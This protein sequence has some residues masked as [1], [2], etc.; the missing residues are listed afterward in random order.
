MQPHA[1]PCTKCT[2]E[3]KGRSSSHRHV[4]GRRLRRRLNRGICHRI[5]AVCV[6]T[7]TTTDIVSL[8]C[9]EQSRI[10]SALVPFL[11]DFFP[12]AHGHVQTTADEHAFTLQ[13]A[14]V[15]TDHRIG[16]S[17]D[18]LE[19]LLARHVP[20]DNSPVFATADG[21]AERRVIVHAR[22]TVEPKAP[23]QTVR[24]IDVTLESLDDAAL[25]VV[26]HADA[27]VQRPGE[28]VLPIRGELD[29]RGRWLVFVDEGPQTLPAMRIPDSDETV[30]CT[31]DNQRPVEDDVNAS[32][33]V[34]VRGQRTKDTGAADVPDENGFVVRAT[35]EDV[36]LG[37][38]GDRVDVVVVAGEWFVMG[39]ALEWEGELMDG[40]TRYQR[41][42]LTVFT[43]H[44]RMVLSS[45][46]VATHC[47]SGLQTSV[48]IPAKW[49]S[50]M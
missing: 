24:G 13:L 41:T 12:H 48:E 37:R 39:S 46:P 19:D 17:L 18:P 8:G 40:C 7:I 33:R 49:P 42:A 43:F 21:E 20:A 2:I 35:D 5:I 22:R 23:R 29:T 11:R 1:T 16:V 27:A 10:K 44:S 26:P 36:A 6:G 9:L 30:Q 45:E 14:G 32:D 28:N 4:L 47:P 38:E 31:R 25:D 34:G 3:I 15:H 50:N